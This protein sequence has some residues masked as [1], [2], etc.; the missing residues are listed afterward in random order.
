MK[1]ANNHSELK[2]PLDSISAVPITR[3][4]LLLGASALG[5]AGISMM[6]SRGLA[7]TRIDPATIPGP[8]W[9]GGTMGGRGVNVWGD[10]SVDFDPLL[11]YGRADYYNLANFFSRADVSVHRLRTAT[12]SCGIV[13]HFFGR[14]G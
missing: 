9:A 7:Q 11:A 5:L 2:H 1:I 3:R 13:G 4:H 12:R 10:T 6:P 14:N 8:A